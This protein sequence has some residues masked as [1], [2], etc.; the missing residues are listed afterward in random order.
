MANYS[1]EK[2]AGV[3]QLQDVKQ[4]SSG[5]QLGA[6][7][8]FRFFF[9]YGTVDRYGS[10][11][12]TI[13]DDHIVLQ[14]RAWPG[15]DFAGAGSQL[16]NQNHITAKIVGGNPVLLGHVYFSLLQGQTGSWLKTNQ[17]GE[18][19]FPLQPVNTISI[20][21]EFCQERFT[22]FNVENSNHNYFEFR[23]EQWLMEVFFNNF[24]LKISKY[25]LAGKHPLM[26]GEK[27]VYEK[28]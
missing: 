23:F 26:K 13:N 8:S 2:I 6:D 11:R 10:G 20:V 9:T 5:F 14:S 12:W 1:M 27:F 4:T 17:K 21:F 28:T 16:V 18:S 24:Q 22:H 25:A 7:G 19:V 3:Y 15:K